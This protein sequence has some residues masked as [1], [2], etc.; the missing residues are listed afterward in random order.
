MAMWRVA[1]VQFNCKLADKAGNLA[2]MQLKLREAAS[3]GAKLIVFPECALTGYGLANREEAAGVAETLPGP[4]TEAFAAVCK[5]LNVFAIFGLIEKAGD[6]LFN[7][8]AIVGPQGFIAGFRKIHMPCIG[9]DRFL[10]KGDRPFEVHDLGGLRIGI[11]ICFDNSFPESVRLMTLQGADLVLQPTNWAD[12][13]IKNATLVARVRAFENSIYYMAVNR[14]GTEAGF[15]YIGHSSITDPGGEFLAFAEHDREAII[16]ADIDPEK[17]R[18]K[19]VVHCAGEYEIDRVNW[20]R[21]EMYKGL[22]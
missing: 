7:A 6:K 17:A 8:A 10:D 15:H 9:I 20:R 1:G 16:I 2:I 22:V 3:H 4:A 5:E 21:P 12:K 14:V 18:Q 13:A 19:K 11:G